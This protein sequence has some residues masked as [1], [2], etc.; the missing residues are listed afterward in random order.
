[1]P[2]NLR[3]INNEFRII[4]RS[5]G[6]A[7]AQRANTALEFGQGVALGTLLVAS[8]IAGYWFIA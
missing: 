8:L 2:F 1:M 6:P 5:R 7:A 3:L 4:R